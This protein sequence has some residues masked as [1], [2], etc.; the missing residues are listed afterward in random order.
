M[1]ASN[2]RRLDPPEILGAAL[3]GF[4]FRGLDP[5]HCGA[6][7]HALTTTCTHFSCRRITTRPLTSAPRTANTFFAKSIPIVVTSISDP[8][9]LCSDVAQDILG[10]LRGRV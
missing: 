2:S 3:P 8:P 9:L 10:P 4:F 5:H 1:F 6:A 7:A